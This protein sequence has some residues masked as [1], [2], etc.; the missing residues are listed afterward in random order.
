MKLAIALYKS[1]E[2]CKDFG[3][4]DQIQRSAVSIPSNIAEG[5]ERNSN[6][7]LFNFFISLKHPVLN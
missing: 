2:G 4:R 1:L 6:R 7:S 3:F 5:F